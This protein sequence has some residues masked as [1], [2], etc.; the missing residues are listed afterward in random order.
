MMVE[1]PRIPVL[2][3]TIQKAYE[4]ENEANICL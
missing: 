1:V 2:E 4:K 3:N